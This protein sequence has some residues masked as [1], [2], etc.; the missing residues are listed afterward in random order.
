MSK[1]KIKKRIIRIKNNE[2]VKDAFNT[3][4]EAE[5]IKGLNEWFGV[6]FYY[7]LRLGRVSFEEHYSKKYKSR[8]IW[9]GY[10]L[11]L[12]FLAIG[13]YIILHYANTT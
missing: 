11:T 3:M 4:N 10:F 5:A 13:I 2:N 7:L 9:T 8:N 1:E 6:I 12:V